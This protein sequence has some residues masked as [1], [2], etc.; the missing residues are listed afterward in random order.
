VARPSKGLLAVLGILVVAVVIAAVV[1][2][3]SRRHRPSRD[4]ESGLHV[5]SLPVECPDMKLGIRALHV[6]PQK[7]FTGWG[8]HVICADPRGC[9]GRVE[10]VFHFVAGGH[11]GQISTVRDIHLGRGQTV[12][13]SLLQRPRTIVERITRVEAKVLDSTG[14]RVVPTPL[15]W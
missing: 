6:V 12:H 11:E 13:D 15:P 4:L 10:I 2:L 5:G 1:L 14:G 7:S 9:E 3:V 8:Y